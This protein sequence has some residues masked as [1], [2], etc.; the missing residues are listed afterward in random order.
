MISKKSQLIKNAFYHEDNFIQDE[1]K[2]QEVPLNIFIPDIDEK[3][4]ILSSTNP[5]DFP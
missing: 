1:T 3:I 5:C 4:K 2:L